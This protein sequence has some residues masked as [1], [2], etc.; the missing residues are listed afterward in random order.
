MRGTITS[1]IKLERFRPSCR[2]FRP[3]VCFK[4]QFFDTTR[5]SAYRRES[6]RGSF[7]TISITS[8]EDPHALS[9]FEACLYEPLA[10]NAQQR[11]ERAALPLSLPFGWGMPVH[12]LL[13]GAVPFGMNGQLVQRPG[14]TPHARSGSPAQ[15]PL[16]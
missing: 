5:V 4:L 15:W 2:P 9:G 16:S 12:E 13:D 11:K 14:L 1:N 7:P 3:D 10:G 6:A 8:H